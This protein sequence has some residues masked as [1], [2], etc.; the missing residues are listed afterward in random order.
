M[1]PMIGAFWNVRGLNK[2]S[3]LKCVSDFICSNKLDFVAL[4]ETKKEIFSVKFL[5]TAGSNFNWHCMPARGTAGGLLIGLNQIEFDIIAWQYFK[6]SVAVIIRNQC[7]SFVWRLIA[8]YGSPYENTKLEFIN[9]LHEV[10]GAWSG[11]TLIGG[12]FNLVRS[13]KEKI[14]GVI[15]FSH[16][17]QFNNWINTWGLLEIKDPNR[18]FSWSN[19]QRPPIMA[20]L[21]RIL[22]YVDWDSKYPLAQVCTVGTPVYITPE[23]FSRREYDRKINQFHIFLLV[24]KS[25]IFRAFH[26]PSLA[27]I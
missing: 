24:L 22:C 20:K 23:V 1:F 18:I 9:E 7:D 15:N 3:R 2:S 13:Q 6:Y 11:P 14:S 5:E 19:N 16:A 27:I 25:I 21:D 12:D 26:W 10:M 8:V 4:Q 17:E